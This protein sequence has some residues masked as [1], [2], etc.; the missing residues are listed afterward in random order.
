[1]K[2]YPRG[3]EIDGVL[4]FL[5]DSA[6]KD[7]PASRTGTPNNTSKPPSTGVT[8]LVPSNI[9]IPSDTD[10]SDVGTPLGS[11]IN[12]TGSRI[13]SR[14]ISIESP[15]PVESAKRSSPKASDSLFSSTE[16][17]GDNLEPIQTRRRSSGNCL[18]F[19]HPIFFSL[20]GRSTVAQLVGC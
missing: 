18:N 10:G 20:T 16:E 14:T 4:I 13:Y 7:T 15:R 17:K 3:K 5:L 9:A 11:T 6:K 12:K 2:N 19:C 1:M 8:P